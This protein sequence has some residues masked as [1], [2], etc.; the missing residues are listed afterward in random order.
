MGKAEVLLGQKERHA[1]RVT[2]AW[3][4]G[5]LVCVC[6][7]IYHVYHIYVCVR[8]M[9]RSVHPF[10]AVHRPGTAWP[11]ADV[12]CLIVVSLSSHNATHTE[13][14]KKKPG[15]EERLRMARARNVLLLLNQVNRRH[16]C[17]RLPAMLARPDDTLTSH[18]PLVCACHV[19]TT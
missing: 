10:K 19:R 3:G 13:I 7:Y 14:K 4:L 2:G 6:V 9:G 5:C 17:A 8:L 11:Q 1:A 15:P 16:V 12:V 18:H